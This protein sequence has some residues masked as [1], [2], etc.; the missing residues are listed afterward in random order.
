MRIVADQC[1]R[2]RSRADRVVVAENPHVAILPRKYVRLDGVIPVACNIAETD[3]LIRLLP[4]GILQY[5][6]E[7]GRIR[8]DITDNRYAFYRKI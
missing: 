2:D 4:P 5:R 6:P 8:M 3:D 7:C 1:V